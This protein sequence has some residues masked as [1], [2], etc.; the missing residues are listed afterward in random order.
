MLQRFAAATPCQS[1]TLMLHS[2]QEL[3]AAAADGDDDDAEVVVV[4]VAAEV[5]ES[6][7]AAADKWQWWQ[8]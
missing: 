7:C 8:W 2:S 6:G 4:V 3:T 5:P 1:V